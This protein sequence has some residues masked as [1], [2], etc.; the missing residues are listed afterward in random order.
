MLFALKD[1]YTSKNLELQAIY[2]GHFD[3][4]QIINSHK[5]YISQ[6]P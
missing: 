1:V 4:Y 5:N 2:L 3:S 6:E